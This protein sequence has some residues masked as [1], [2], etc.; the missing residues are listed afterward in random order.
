[1]EY[2]PVYVKEE[3]EEEKKCS[4]CQAIRRTQWMGGG[5]CKRWTRLNCHLKVHTVEKLFSCSQVGKSF[6]NFRTLQQHLKVHTGERP[7]SC[8]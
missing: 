8:P 4:E 5:V 7:H 3:T 2:S 6:G 1:M